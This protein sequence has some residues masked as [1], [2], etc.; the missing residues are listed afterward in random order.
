MPLILTV[1]ELTTCLRE[2]LESDER[3]ADLWVE[4]EISNVTRSSAGHVYFTLKE[5]EAQIACVLFRGYANRLDIL[6]VDGEAVLVH[7][8]ISFY[9]A[10]GKLQLYAD[11]VRSL[12]LGVLY[13]RFQQLKS[14]LEAEG[15]FAPEHKRPLPRF[16]RCIGVVTSPTGAVIR[17][18]LHI[19]KRRYPPVRVILSP[20]LV[21][22]KEAAPMIVAALKRLWQFPVDLI[23]VARGGGSLEDLWPFNEEIVA[24][25]IRASPVP[26]ISGVGHETD[27]TIADFAADVRAPTP[28]AAA[29]IAVPD[30]AELL[31]T[32]AQRRR[33]L[34]QALR[35]RLAVAR[36][37]LEIQRFHLH[38]LSPQSRLAQRR[39]RLDEQTERAT[40]QI[41]YRVEIARQ[42][43]EGLSA[44][45]ATLDPRATLRR[46][47]AIVHRRADGALVVNPAQVAP[48]DRLDIRV[49]D[50]SFEAGAL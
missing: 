4:G 21:Q 29:E 5:A 7:G 30:A 49:R 18:I 13:L 19:L 36:Q 39:Q 2:L 12:G 20:T 15:L 38:R 6:P 50:G 37:N 45:L 8:R 48:G 10:G 23:I 31:Q 32:V 35:Q 11:T 46:G 1:R 44:R 42:R 43:L 27:F 40:R 34:H 28:S 16:P 24:R 14:A 33:R 17:D 25:A 47:Y 9:E 22:G 41:R 26:V 3:L